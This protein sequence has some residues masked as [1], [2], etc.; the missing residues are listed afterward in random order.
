MR[1]CAWRRIEKQAPKALV[2]APELL[3]ENRFRAARDG[4]RAELLDPTERRTLAVPAVAE[5]AVS[6]CRPHAHELGCERSL[7]L[8]ERLV[9]EPGYELQRKLAGPNEDLQA[10]V[11]GLSQRFTASVPVGV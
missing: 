7:D 10:V 1:W 9:D 2:D 8:V 3:E 6:A 5:L 11:A 4:V